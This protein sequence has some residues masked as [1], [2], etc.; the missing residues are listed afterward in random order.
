MFYDPPFPLRSLPPY[1]IGGTE[2]GLHKDGGKMAGF[3]LKTARLFKT[4]QI[5]ASAGANAEAWH[6][7]AAQVSDEDGGEMA[8]FQQ[9][10]V[11]ARNRPI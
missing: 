7:Y 11:S 3:Q 1:K 9:P 4:G 6:R 2:G 8:V 10:A 5:V